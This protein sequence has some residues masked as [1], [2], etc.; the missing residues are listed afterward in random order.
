MYEIYRKGTFAT[1]SDNDDDEGNGEMTDWRTELSVKKYGYRSQDIA[2]MQGILF[3][4]L[5]ENQINQFSDSG[6]HSSTPSIIK[7]FNGQDS[8]E[9]SSTSHSPNIIRESIVT[10]VTM[11]W[12]VAPCNL[13]EIG[14]RLTGAYCFHH[15]GERCWHLTS[16]YDDARR[17]G[18]TS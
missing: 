14:R 8:T 10:K 1:L 5:I 13:V 9:F 6:I 3:N 4:T 7:T 16:T 15:K 12:N 18:T 11:L 17:H 2:H